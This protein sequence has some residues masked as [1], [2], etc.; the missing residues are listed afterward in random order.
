MQLTFNPKE[1]VKTLGAELITEF[2]KAGLA[3]QSS[4]VGTGRETSVK[5][6]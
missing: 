3:T 6:N 2:D 1:F 4:A 5:Q